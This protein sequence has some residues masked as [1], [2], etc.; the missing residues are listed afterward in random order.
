MDNL[1]IKSTRG[2]PHSILSTT[3]LVSAKKPGQLESGYV[4]SW[5]GAELRLWCFTLNNH[6]QWLRR[7]RKNKVRHNQGKGNKHKSQKIKSRRLKIK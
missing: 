5:R 3:T 4:W 7:C 2:P 1:I 6:Y